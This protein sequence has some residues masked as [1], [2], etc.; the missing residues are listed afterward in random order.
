MF[1]GFGWFVELDY[2][3]AFQFEEN[4]DLP[5]DN[6][7]IFDALERDGLDSQELVFVIFDVSSI[8]RTE[9][10]LAQLD[11]GDH[12]ALYYFAGHDSNGLDK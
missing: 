6:F 2:V 10:S 12:V 1:G 3:W 9:A 4:F 5:S 7:F 8:D 11:R